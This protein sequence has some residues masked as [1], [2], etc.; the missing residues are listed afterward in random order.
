L[1]IAYCGYK[2]NT[3]SR[4]ES[5]QTAQS[6]SFFPEIL[7]GEFSFLRGRREILRVKFWPF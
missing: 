5:L 6:I 4:L 2:W 7:R 3:N 1:K